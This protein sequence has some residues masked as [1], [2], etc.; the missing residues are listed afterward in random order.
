[1]IC[2]Q[3]TRTSLQDCKTSMIMISNYNVIQLTESGANDWKKG[4]VFEAPES[5]RDWRIE[6]F[7]GLVIQSITHGFGVFLHFDLKE[8]SEAKPLK[9]QWTGAG[10]NP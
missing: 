7:N 5:C 3:S 4:D 2:T 9:N 10:I 8:W 1:M 6:R